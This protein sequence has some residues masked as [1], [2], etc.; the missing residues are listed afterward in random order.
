MAGNHHLE[1]CG[2]CGCPNDHE[3]KPCGHQVTIRV[4][5]DGDE[6]VERTEECSCIFGVRTDVMLCRQNVKLIQQN[7]ELIEELH[8][9]GMIL[10]VGFNLEVSERG[11]ILPKHGGIVT[12][13][14]R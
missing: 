10:L 11:E 9:L 1:R 12:P 8:N 6:I 5:G 4:R 13:F 7:E 3:N 2:R 14:G